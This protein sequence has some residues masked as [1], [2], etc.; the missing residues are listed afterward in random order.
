MRINP[1]KDLHKKRVKFAPDSDVKEA[2]ESSPKLNRDKMEALN[3]DKLKKSLRE[4][5]DEKSTGGK[6]KT[7]SL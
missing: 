2:V 4:L 6:S 5:I 7:F 3:L 1:K